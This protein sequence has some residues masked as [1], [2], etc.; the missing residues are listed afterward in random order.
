MVLGKVDACFLLVLLSGIALYFDM[1][2]V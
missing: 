1:T 2:N